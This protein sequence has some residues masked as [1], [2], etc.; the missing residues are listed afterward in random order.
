MGTITLR[1]PDD[2]HVHLRQD[3]LLTS[4]LPHTASVFGRA[5]VMPNTKPAILTGEDAKRYY[6]D[7]YCLA[8][9][10]EYRLFNPLMTIQI[11]DATT[12]EMIVE[13]RKARV[14]AGK[15]YPVGVTTNSENGLSSFSTQKIKE[16]FHAMQEV[17]MALSLHGE[18]PDPVFCLDR[19]AEFLKRVL[20]PIAYTYRHLRIVLEHITTRKAVDEIRLLPKHVA[21]TI[22]GHHLCLTLDDVIGDKLSPHHFCKPIAKRPNDRESILEAATS[23]EDKFFLGTDS[24]PHFRGTKECASGCAGVFTAPMILPLL[25][26]V[27]EQRG[28]LDKLEGFTSVH[29]AQFYNLSLNDGTIT[30]GKEPFVVE[31]E[32]A[33]V[34]PFK[35]GETLSWRVLDA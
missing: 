21:A 30:L 19:E 10:Q 13:A 34:V 11:T 12:P 3:Y 17:G 15:V 2:F 23:G 31:K 25:A 26:E 35:A 14:V 9:K 20:L 8:R 32:Y 16:V 22:T 24:A 33:G 27:F 5:L 1:R 18:M 4:V 28:A 7:I 29:G 6:D